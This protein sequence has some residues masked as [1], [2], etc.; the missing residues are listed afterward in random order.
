[1]CFAPP[2]DISHLCISSNY[3]HARSN[4][5]HSGGNCDSFK[6]PH[7]FAAATLREHCNAATHA[8]IY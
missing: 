4:S 1:M 6:F 7:V 5:R 2:S 3:N 8:I